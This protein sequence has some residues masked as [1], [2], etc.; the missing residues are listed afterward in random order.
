MQ[1]ETEERVESEEQVVAPTNA[2]KPFKVLDDSIEFRDMLS[3]VQDKAL[4][5][6][7][8]EMPIYW[9]LLR[10]V[11]ENDPES[12]FSEARPVPA[13]NNLM[14][15][16]A[17]YR[18]GLFKQQLVV[19]SVR[20]YPEDPS[21]DPEYASEGTLE[22]DSTKLIYEVWGSTHQAPLWLQILVTD[23]LPG[24]ETP[25]SLEGK[26]IDM[27][28]YFFKLQGYYPAK[29]KPS[30]RPM[31]SPV[32]MGKAEI[33]VLQK[34]APS[35]STRFVSNETLFAILAGLLI[36][37]LLLKNIVRM[38]PAPRKRRKRLDDSWDWM[39][40]NKEE[41]SGGAPPN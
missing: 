41:Q 30:D 33:A 22:G 10:E 8:R 38:K 12:F 40:S 19:R 2:G 28:G 7:P 23:Q 31:I 16:P 18:A 5:L 29:S 11:K 36:C 37:S 27:A 20:S 35:M 17:Q 32:F 25:E 3:V 4:E 15:R 26:S 13:L 24:T 39:E 1:V 9:R 34:P 6:I 21:T 14:L